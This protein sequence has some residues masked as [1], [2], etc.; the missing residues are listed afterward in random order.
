[1]ADVL[2]RWFAAINARDVAALS[3]LMAP[4]FVFVDSLG[5]EV[6]GAEKMT[7]GWRA[8]FAMCPDYWIRVH[9]VAPAAGATLIAGEAGGTI[10]GTTWRTPAAWRIVIHDDQVAEFRVFADNKPVYDIL[11]RRSREGYR[12]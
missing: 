2:Q 7:V 4:D 9:D 3:S 1:M 11:A 10:D 6:R 12:P 5:N 8:Y